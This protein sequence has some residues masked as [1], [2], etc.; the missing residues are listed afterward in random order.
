ML[1]IYCVI[2]LTAEKGVVENNYLVL[3]QTKVQKGFTWKKKF[4]N[5]T[6]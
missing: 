1:I 2:N 4:E 3:L 6:S 5:P